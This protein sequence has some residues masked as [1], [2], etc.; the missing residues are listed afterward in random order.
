MSRLRRNILYNLAGQVLLMGLG[1]LAVRFVFRQLG[2]DAFGI[3]LFSQTINAVLVAVLELGLSSTTIRE[4]AAHFI[5]EPGYVRD[6]LRT[7]TLLYWGAYLLLAAGLVLS[8]PL[9]VGHW[10]HLQSMDT[11]TAV[12]LVQILGLG[13]LLTLPRSLYISLLRGLQEMGFVNTIDVGMLAAQQLGMIAILLRGGGPMPVVL[14]LS[15]TYLLAIV[16]YLLVS[17]RFVGWPAL[18]PGWAREAINRNLTFSGRMAVISTLGM[19]H[20]Q[21][22]KLAVSKLLP[23][24]DLGTYGFA[25]TLASGVSRVT[26]SIVQAGFPAFAALHQEGDRTTLMRQYRRLHLLVTCLT[27]PFFAALTFGTTPIFAYVFNPSVARALVIPV[28]LLCGGWFLNAT[29]NVPYVLSLAMGR[30]DIAARQNLL[31]LVAVLPVA[32]LA[33]VLFGLRGAAFGWVFYQLFAYAYGVPRI[34]RECLRMSPLAWYREVARVTAV[35]AVT[36]GVAYW[37]ALT[38]GRGSLWWLAACYA[39][40]SALYAGGVYLVAGRDLRE[41]L[42]AA[43]RVPSVEA[44]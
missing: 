21:S 25:S 39:V 35:L 44:A 17:A 28:A 30:P 2:P 1:L 6:L 26:T 18:Q 13:T 5:D 27:P 40:S 11:E 4:V 34:C 20:M 29:L 14:W 7:A 38:A 19:V 37:I 41:L 43:A 36:Y 8:A 10:I 31:A 33:V 32:V 12:R 15:A 42:P 9:I 24:G 16:A 23:I 3:V 22:D